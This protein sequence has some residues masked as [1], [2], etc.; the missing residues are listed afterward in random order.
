MHNAK[1]DKM[2]VN[3]LIYWLTYGILSLWLRQQLSIT[4]YHTT[5]DFVKRYKVVANFHLKVEYQIR[6]YKGVFTM[7][8]LFIT[9][10]LSFIIGCIGSYFYITYN[11]QVSIDNPHTVSTTIF[12]Q[13]N[14]YHCE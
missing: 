13:T 12:G 14:T 8:K 1:S 5:Q 11:I 6:Q 9:A 10:L 4:V 3:L 2:L 7:T